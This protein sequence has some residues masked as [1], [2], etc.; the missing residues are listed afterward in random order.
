[1]SKVKN[2]KKISLDDAVQFV[3]DSDESDVDSC[4]DGLSSDEEEAIDNALLGF[5][6]FVERYDVNIFYCVVAT[7]VWHVGVQSV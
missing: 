4:N 7:F 3:L 5:D 1:M 6:T 2:Q